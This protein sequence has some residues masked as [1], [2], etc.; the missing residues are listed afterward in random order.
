MEVLLSHIVAVLIVSRQRFETETCSLWDWHENWNLGN[1][2][3]QKRVSRPLGAV[4]GKFDLSK[5]SVIAMY[6]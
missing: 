6:W 1:W 3:S 4:A 2:D 5:N